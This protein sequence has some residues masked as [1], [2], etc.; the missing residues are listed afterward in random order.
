M[1]KHTPAEHDEI[2]LFNLFLNLWEGRWTIITAILFSVVG[3]WIYCI[4]KS[5][6]TFVAT[7]EIRPIS[8]SDL[9]A[10]TLSNE[11]GFFPIDANLLQD[12]FIEELE[13]GVVLQEAIRKY[14]LLDE[15]QFET[16]EEFDE[17][18]EIFASSIVIQPPEITEVGSVKPN[19]RN[20]TFSIEYHDKEKWKMAIADS[21]ASATEIIR[22]LLKAR[23]DDK[24][25]TALLKQEFALEDLSKTI[26][27]IKINYDKQM[28]EFEL[29]H[30]FALA[31]IQT[32]IDNALQDY[33]RKAESRSA[34]LRE[35]AAI[36]RKLKVAKNTIEAQTY[37]GQNNIVTNV[38]SD[39]PFYLRGYEAIE[40]EIK[41][42][43]TRSNEKLFVTGLL[44]LE[45]EQ[46]SLKQDQTLQR[47][48][49]NK[50]F[51]ASLLDLENQQRA[52]RQNETIDRAKKQFA[53][54]PLA[55]GEN[56]KAVSI[57]IPSTKFEGG[58]NINL[59]FALAI[60]LGGFMGSAYVLISKAARERQ[61]VSLDKKTYSEESWF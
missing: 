49:Q 50:L 41:L 8:T 57:S 60:V 53:L 7:T 30:G 31:D 55:T 51:L 10:Y 32:K 33:V 54:T 14:E 16:T 9:D 1:Q 24:V 34:Y 48:D 37:N 42:I 4:V 39:T 29:K 52:I 43:E 38:K 56:F 12:L 36:A 15:K 59:L 35:Q 18:I 58:A 45:A 3:V 2:D 61:R 5:P 17:A 19:R 11:L 13:N 20:W 26:E 40:E 28:Q 23:F 46:R 27:N 22:L 47:A 21:V 44:E 6:S 25:S